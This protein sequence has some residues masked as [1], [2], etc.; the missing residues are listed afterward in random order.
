MTSSQGKIFGIGLSKTGTTSLASALQILGYRTKDNMGVVVYSAGDL[1]SI[2]L[3]VVDTHDALTDTPIPSFYRQL[4]ARYPGSKF[5]LTVRDEEGWLQSCQKQFT[6]RLAEKRN[7]A[8]RRLFEDLYGT[9]I[10]DSERFAAGYKRFIA[11]VGGYFRDRPKD[12]LVIDVTA[13]EGWDKLCPFLGCAQPAIPFPKAN[14]TQI[15]WIEMQTLVS[16]AERGGAELMRFYE[17]RAGKC[18]PAHSRHSLLSHALRALPGWDPLAS[19]RRSAQRVIVRELNRLTPT[20]P[21]LSRLDAVAPYDERKKW[22]HL[23]LVDPL[24]GEQAFAAGLPDF[25]VNIALVEDTRPI[26]GVVVA[27]AH[28]IT[29]FARSGKSAFIVVQ[30][31][32]P[33]ILSAVRWGDE[34]PSTGAD[35]DAHP[36]PEN[37][38]PSRALSLCRMTQNVA[39]Q[40]DVSQPTMEW[41]T[42]AAQVVAQEAGIRFRANGTGTD[43]TYN[44]QALSNDSF[45]VD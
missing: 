36:L 15:R 40:L 28:G 33:K 3:S 31:G 16:V 17:G 38:A 21:V 43:L 29:Y 9:D 41:E 10:F 6:P 14:V 5:I 37:A 44:K 27:P 32:S 7:E 11:D 42:A 26:Y 22:N 34:I 12:L 23:W 2:D 18:D 35:R 13:G 1:T 20:I 30:G 39:P 24:D 19:A 25:S 4:D 45:M 8:H